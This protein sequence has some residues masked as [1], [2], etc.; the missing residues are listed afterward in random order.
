MPRK[1][2][3]FKKAKAKREFEK[4]KHQAWC[5][6]M[7]LTDNKTFLCDGCNIPTSVYA[8]SSVI[9]CVCDKLFCRECS[10]IDEDGI[11]RGTNCFWC[12]LLKRDHT[13]K[14]KDFVESRERAELKQLVKYLQSVGTDFV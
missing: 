9:V 7:I 4:A 1:S 5:L 13:L 8:Y 14:I 11:P 3:K 12:T 2:A 10:F 6:E